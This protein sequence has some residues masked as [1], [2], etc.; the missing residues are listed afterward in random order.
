MGNDTLKQFPPYIFLDPYIRVLLVHKGKLWK[1]WRSSIKYKTLNPIFNESF[2]F[3][4]LGSRIEDI[5]LD[6][7]VVDSDRKWDDIIGLVQFNRESSTESSANKHWE[8]MLLSPQFVSQ[9]HT[10]KPNGQTIR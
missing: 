9:W 4:L 7:L 1:D 5:Q 10:L 2:H 6:I 8:E 3:D